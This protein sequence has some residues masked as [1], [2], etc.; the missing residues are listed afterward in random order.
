MLEFLLGFARLY[1]PIV[2][3][4]RKAL[5]QTGAECIVDL[6][7]GAGGPWLWMHGLLEEPP[8]VSLSVCLTD[9]YPNAGAF[10]HTKNV[11]NNRITYYASAVDAMQI[12]AELKG[13]RTLFTSFHHFNPDEARAI[14]QDAVRNQQGIGIFEIAGRRPITFLGVFL[15]PV[16]AL[17]L[18]AVVRPFRWS[19]LIWSY[20][21]PIVPFVLFF[22]GIVS[23]LRTYSTQELTELTRGL[24][25]S[26][27]TWEIGREKQWFLSLPVTYLIGY[28]SMPA[29]APE[30]HH[31]PESAMAVPGHRFSAPPVQD[32]PPP[33]SSLDPFEGKPP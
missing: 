17:L 5:K 18:A 28:P 15:I 19:R 9:K 4:L 6:C 24:S 31:R 32:A 25:A 27:Y 23:C 2:P 13:F 7:S 22:D 12:P 33:S 21:I 3:R 26:G 16:V 29:K 14:L 1:A 30:K 20:L 10:G 11:S 8:N